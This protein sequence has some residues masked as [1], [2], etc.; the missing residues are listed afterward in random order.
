[1]N[2]GG[3][4]I[5]LNAVVIAFSTKAGIFKRGMHLTNLLK[6]ENNHFKINI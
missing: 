5:A 1:M 6:I 4:K 2:L 3:N